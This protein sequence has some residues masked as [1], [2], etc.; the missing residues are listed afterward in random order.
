VEWERVTSSYDRVASA[1][2]DLFIDELDSKPRDRELLEALAAS[3][4]DPVVEIGSGPG[5]VG[6]FVRARGRRVIGIDLSAAMARLANE[7]LD[8]AV[9]AD[10]RALPVASSHCGGV[11]AFYSVIHLPRAELSVALNEFGRILRPG[12][13]L[14]FSAH[15]GSGEV[16][17]DNFI[18]QG[19]PM[20][21]TLFE[22]DELVAAT[23][24]AG[25]AVRVA[26]RR[27]PYATEGST[28]RLY[29]EAKRTARP[30]ASPTN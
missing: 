25:L 22:L 5:Q 27:P 19:V 28:T 14:L 20:V 9:V 21:A 29:I 6:S 16:T 2:E 4:G 13:W 18:G 10:M 8:G 24:A 12:G 23:E 26:E 7:R 30:P 11:L 15:E 1:Y 3:A 17:V